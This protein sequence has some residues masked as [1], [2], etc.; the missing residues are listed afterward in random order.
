MNSTRKKIGVALVAPSGY[1]PD[2]QALARGIACLEQQG[3]LVHNYY[4]PGKKYQRFGGTDAARLAQFSSAARD[5]DVQ[6]VMAVRGSYGISR[7]LPALDFNMLAE[8]GKLFVGYSDFNAFN[9]GLLAQ[10]GAPSFS[11]P[12]LSG[13]FGI[14]NPSE[15]TRTHFWACLQG[16]DHKIGI[17]AENNPAIAVEG[18]L[19]GGNLAMLAHLVGSPYLPHIEGGILFIEDI[20]EHPF[21]VERM[22]LQLHHAGILARQ[23]ALLLGDFSGYRLGDFDNG[24]D[25][26]AMLSFLRAHL[27]LPILTGLPFGHTLDKLTLPI[28]GRAELVSGADGFVL[29]LKDYP[30]LDAGW[31][32]KSD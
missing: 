26:Q 3:C 17:A 25:F 8:S 15:F 11:G 5:P 21:R 13:D 31:G 4:D 6:I 24:Y 12:M 29:H 19:W 10:T 30:T 27:P 9:L 22:I 23:K 7:I 14:E 1:V 18:T 16:P 20:A 2:D 32:A 28:G